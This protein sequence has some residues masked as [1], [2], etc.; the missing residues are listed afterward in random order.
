[1]AKRK[2]G[3]DAGARKDAK[4]S[5]VPFVRTIE[6]DES[7]DLQTQLASG[8]YTDG[9]GVFS[10]ILMPCSPDEFFE[11]T[12]E[13]MPLFISRPSLRQWYS[14]WLSEESIFE[15]L[16]DEDSDVQYGFNLDVTAYNGEERQDF[17]YNSDPAEENGHVKAALV[18]QRFKQQGASL[19][20]LHP[21]RYFPHLAHRMALLEQVF[22]TCVGCNAY[23]TPPD[24]QGF[25]PHWDDIDAFILQLE[26][27]KRWR[28]AKHWHKQE[29]YLARYSSPDL[30]SCD[31]SEWDDILLQP[32]DMLYMP[33][34]V[35]HQAQAESG[36]S[37][38][39][40]TISA[41][42]HNTWA[43]FLELALPAAVRIASEEVLE[44][45]E[46]LPQH[47]TSYMGVMHSTDEALEI[48]RAAFVERAH[49]ALDA[50]LQN[51]PFD[52]TADRMAALFLRQRL[53]PPASVSEVDRPGNGRKLSK[54]SKV[55]LAG[56]DIARLVGE[57]DML[58]VYHCMSNDREKHAS[59]P[60]GADDEAYSG[61][62]EF[63]MD[64]AG[65][66]ESLLIELPF[67]G[68][69][70]Q[71]SKVLPSITEADVAVAQRLHGAGILLVT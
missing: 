67:H 48:E 29:N 54:T 25:A 5:S 58:V 45:R 69:G 56:K 46:S 62:L 61:R 63:D 57:D 40:L 3:S 44:M 41:N 32:G 1:M 27:S 70:K 49:S 39:H 7:K 64:T 6:T 31:F 23:L 38:L 42:Q 14:D 53:P 20:L 15:L 50:V 13:K 33:R 34:G 19:R 30:A 59:A 10:D 16:A 65:T 66:L 60:S 18:R 68:K 36:M 47:F 8:P 22:G 43:D 35:I 17:N 11:H 9:D 21:Q 4:T 26:G 71:L 52:S 12:W 24:S 37:S 55:C 28:I 51:I 2:A